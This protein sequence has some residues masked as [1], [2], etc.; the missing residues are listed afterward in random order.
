MRLTRNQSTIVGIVTLAFCGYGLLSLLVLD[1]P[2][3]ITPDQLTFIEGAVASTNDVGI[4]KGYGTLEIS[5]I[6]Q[7]LPFR[8]FDGPYPGSFDRDV[9]RRMMPGKNVRIGVVTSELASPRR[10]R[11]QGQSFYSFVCLDVEGRSA[12]TLEAYNLWSRKNLKTGLI[13][14]L[15]LMCCGA[16]LIRA[17]CVACRD[18]KSTI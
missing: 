16:Y 15:L 5:V 8:C 17:G 13:L 2:G 6:G 18:G 12:L 11:A 1:P 3:R 7:E 4:R 9:L 10:N 14:L